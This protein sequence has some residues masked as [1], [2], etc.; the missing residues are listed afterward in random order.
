MPTDKQHGIGSPIFDGDGQAVSALR[1]AVPPLNGLRLATMVMLWQ[2]G[3][4]RTRPLL[5]NSLLTQMFGSVI[6]GEHVGS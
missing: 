4:R 2:P 6:L 1:K 5:K 3:N